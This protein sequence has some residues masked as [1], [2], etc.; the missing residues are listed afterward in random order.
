[1]RCRLSNSARL[2]V[3]TTT[4]YL[5][6]NRV[7]SKE[8]MARPDKSLDKGM[9]LSESMDFML[10]GPLGSGDDPRFEYPIG[11]HVLVDQKWRGQIVSRRNGY[12]PPHFDCWF[13]IY[14]VV[15]FDNEPGPFS[16]GEDVG[17]PRIEIIDY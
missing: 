7:P 10:C 5:W 15:P 12:P 3:L 11:A 17:P 8:I 1:M 13:P 9:N 16:G 4:N 14:F 2:P 6:H